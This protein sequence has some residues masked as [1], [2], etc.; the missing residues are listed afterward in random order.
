MMTFHIIEA[1]QLHGSIDAEQFEDSVHKR[2]RFVTDDDVSTRTRAKAA[3]KSDDDL[4][5]A[6]VSDEVFVSS[7]PL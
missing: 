6:S 4:D 3:V 1:I 7:K 5:T 2:Y